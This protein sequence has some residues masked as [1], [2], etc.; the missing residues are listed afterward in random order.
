MQLARGALGRVAPVMFA[1][2]LAVTG[3]VGCNEP[4]TPAR[5]EP[6]A[7]TTASRSADPGRPVRV[8]NGE[9]IIPSE[10]SRIAVLWPPAL[11]TLV[12][13]G[14]QPLA[15]VGATDEPDGG[16]SPY[17]PADFEAKT[18]EVVSASPAPEDLD[19]DALREL[20]PDLIIG[21]DA[22]GHI[23]VTVLAELSAIAPTI[24]LTADDTASW[25]EQVRQL[26][27]VLAVPERAEVLLA[28]YEA[29]VAAVRDRL[30][31]PEHTT[32]SILRAQVGEEIRVEPTD[33]F[34]SEIIAD[35]GF[36]RPP[37]QLEVTSAN[38][39][40]ISADELDRVDA[41][42]V[43]VLTDSAD[44]QSADAHSVLTSAAW[45]GLDAVAAGRAYEFDAALWSAEN[46]DAALR[47]LADIEATLS[48]T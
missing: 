6:G 10:P 34:A 24:L 13:L 8:S 3:L 36:R 43:I 12:H 20:A 15:S 40:V 23:G 2:V 19:L 4:T 26:G 25:R 35:L 21:T 5:E 16:L 28:D 30:E 1:V 11:S 9:I 7:D 38:P 22:E 39:V 27:E 48:G 33:S 31:R 32:V 17:L 46:Y 45:R 37:D 14:Q 42:I 18:L 44:A 47:V 29:R 41:D